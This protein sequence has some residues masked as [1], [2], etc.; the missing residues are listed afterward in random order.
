MES[1]LLQGEMIMS[2]I[3]RIVLAFV[4]L[5]LVL[6]SFLVTA[7]TKDSSTEDATIE[8]DGQVSSKDE[9]VYAT[10][11]ATGKAQEMYVVNTLDIV[12]AGKVTDYGSY[13]QIKNLTDL[14]EIEQIDDTVQ[15]NAQEGKFYYQGNM[16]A[17][18]LPWDIHVTY[19]LDGKEIFPEDLAGQSGRV[20]IHIETSANEAV[21]PV[22]F[23]NYLLQISMMF[24]AENTSNIKAKDG[25][26]ANAGKN[27]QVTFTAMPE[28]AD[29]FVVEADVVDFELDGIDIT[30]VPSSMSIDA[31]DLDEMTGDMNT[32]TAAITE[33]NDGVA[34][35]KNGVSELNNGV[36]EL[37][38]GSKQYKDGMSEID[39]A[40]TSLVNGSKEIDQALRTMRSSLGN[41]EEI[42]LS[43]LEQLTNGLSQIATGLRETE[44]GLSTLKNN[45]SDAYHA[46]EGAMNAINITEEEIQRLNNEGV[47]QRVVEQLT[48]ALTAKQTYNQV[49]Q[50]FDAVDSTLGTVNRSLTEMANQLDKMVQGLS[51]S[52]EN[53]DIAS[54]ISQLQEGLKSLSSNYKIF[55][56][57]LL[58]YTK[59]VSELSSSYQKLHNGIGEL[60]NGTVQFESGVGALHNGTTELH[61]ST[62]DLPEQMTEEIDE[63]IS[64]Y[65]KSDFE[66]VS[67]VSDKNE[68]VN[69]VQF[70]L[71]TD[72]IKS[73]DSDKTEETEERSE[74]KGFWA[75][76]KELF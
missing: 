43:E 4:V 20:K 58:E 1:K 61:E 48:A 76:L 18:T 47:E 49:S 17:A 46:V 66:A 19:F 23:E 50:V 45:Y 42:D 30:G 15:F 32:L 57:G 3:K 24:D 10:L 63:M 27:K 51:S 40:S 52:L 38:D 35:L 11:S 54:G 59:G 71:K 6:P 13:D 56:S 12:K 31:P 9:V 67:F 8:Q 65:D 14:T 16:N 7:S 53:M 29:E 22:F 62:S 68:N 25:T 75:R 60:A 39:K 36:A 55:H 37:K 2:R 34:E 5:L 64:E 26:I 72:S 69:S 41:V 74:E 33:V 44:T 73:E 70:V 21:N 28:Q